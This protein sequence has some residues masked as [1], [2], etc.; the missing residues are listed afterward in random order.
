MVQEKIESCPTEQKK[1]RTGARG[2]GTTLTATF[3]KHG[4]SVPAAH[5]ASMFFMILAALLRAVVACIC[6]PSLFSRLPMNLCH[7]LVD[8]FCAAMDEAHANGLNNGSLVVDVG[9]AYGIEATI[10]RQRGHSVI[11]FEC[12]QDEFRRLRAQFRNDAL[13]AVEHACV[14]DRVGSATLLR[15]GHSSSLLA[16]S[17]SG[18]QEMKLAN[19]ERQRQEEVRLV[20][21]DEFLSTVKQRLG[22]LRLTCRA[23]SPQC[24]AA[25]ARL[26]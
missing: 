12:R 19:A 15:A 14:S 8:P 18:S 25:L 4:I 11:S 22:V 23:T 3:V 2:P 20:V 9:A 13:V 7:D 5:G 24:C 10:A 21:L 17:L 6:T 1:S 26:S 16:S